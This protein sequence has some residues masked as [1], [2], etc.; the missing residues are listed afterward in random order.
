MVWEARSQL[1]SVL[2]ATEPVSPLADLC[3]SNSPGISCS[4]IPEGKELECRICW[5]LVSSGGRGLL[6][7]K[8]AKKAPL[9]IKMIGR[10][11]VLCVCESFQKGTVSVSPFQDFLLESFSKLRMLLKVIP[12]QPQGSS[13]LEILKTCSQ[14][15]EK[16]VFQTNQSKHYHQILSTIGFECPSISKSLSVWSSDRLVNLFLSW[17]WAPGN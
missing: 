10:G 7:E 2:L 6:K 8:T 13:P 16:S 17:R 9:G 12:G 4:V 5:H 11:A 3:F 14:V 15:L 1:L